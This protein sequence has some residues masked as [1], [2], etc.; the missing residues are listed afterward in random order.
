MKWSRNRNSPF[1]L[2][3]M[4]S[5]NSPQPLNSISHAFISTPYLARYI[6]SPYLNHRVR[7]IFFL[8]SSHLST[9][10]LH[11]LTLNPS[12]EGEG[13]YSTPK[14]MVAFDSQACVN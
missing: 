14:G 10:T 13:L 4:L 12:P 11:H 8:H 9:C 7:S 1:G 5:I 2:K 6:T 3:Q